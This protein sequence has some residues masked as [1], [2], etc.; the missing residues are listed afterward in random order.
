VEKNLVTTTFLSA[1]Q[2]LM[3]PVAII[4]CWEYIQGRLKRFVDYIMCGRLSTRR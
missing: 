2:V 1:H 3:C 4:N